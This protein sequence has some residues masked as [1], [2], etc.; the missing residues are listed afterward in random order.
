MAISAMSSAGELPTRTA[1]RVLPSNRVTS[2]EV[3]LPMTWALVSTSP[4]L[5]MITPDPA[6]PEIPPLLGLAPVRIDTTDGW[7][8]VSSDAMLRSSSSKASG[9]SMMRSTTRCPP[10]LPSTAT[11]APAP[12]M[13]ARNATTITVKRPGP[14]RPAGAGGG[15]VGPDGGP[16]PGCGWVDGGSTGGAPGGAGQ[17]GAAAGAGGEGAAGAVGAPTRVGAA[18]PVNQS[19]ACSPSTP[20]GRHVGGSS[21]AMGGSGTVGGPLGASDHV[22][23]PPSSPDPG[24]STSLPPCG[25]ATDSAVQAILSAAYPRSPTLRGRPLASAMD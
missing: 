23:G 3:E 12:S 6:P 14:R 16:Q 17:A 18:E 21:A 9:G 4:S 24:L 5:E 11:A 10:W 25:P 22:R 1:S 13:A 7:A 19:G 20:A 15:G 2:A 8:L